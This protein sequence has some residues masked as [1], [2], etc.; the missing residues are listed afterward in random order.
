MN[1]FLSHLAGPCCAPS[2]DQ[3]NASCKLAAV[4]LVLHVMCATVIAAAYQLQQV[5]IYSSNLLAVSVWLTDFVMVL[6]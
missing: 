3:E 2:V 5:I 1:V 4:R 6:K